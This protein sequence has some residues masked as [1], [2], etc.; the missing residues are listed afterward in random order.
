MDANVRAS[1]CMATW[2]GERY[3]TEQLESILEQIGPDDEVVVVDDAST[4]GTRDVIRAID[5][6]RI[7][8]IAR[9]HNLGYVKTFEEALRESRGEYLFLSDQDDLWL[10]GRFDAMM[11]ALEDHDVVASNLT[12]LGVSATLEGPFGQPDWRL[13]SST[14]SHRAR[15]VVGILTQ[16][17]PYYGCAMALRRSALGNGV[18]PFPSFLFESH[19]TWIALY[20]NIRGRMAHLDLRSVARRLHDDNAT[21][22]R[23]RALAKVLRSRVMML[24]CIAALLA[25]RG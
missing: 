8:L 25:R 7:R 24:R 18:L 15:N 12:T 19:D 23:P 5:D 22:N 4:D 2:N 13:R 10:P 14:S 16:A 21:P 3:V 1:V 20:G 11:E 17:L 9:S 6:P